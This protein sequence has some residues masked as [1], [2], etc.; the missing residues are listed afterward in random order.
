MFICTY[1][2]HTAFYACFQFQIYC[3]SFN[4]P[5]V[6]CYYLYLHIWTTSLNHVHMY[7][8][9]TPF[10]FI[11]IL[12]GCIWQPWILM[13][14][15]WS[16]D[17]G[18]LAVAD[19]STQR[20]LPWW[21]ECRKSSDIAVVLPPSF[22]PVWLSR[23]LL[24]L[25]SISQLLLYISLHVLYFYIFCWCNIPVILYHSLWWPCTCTIL[26]WNVYYHCASASDSSCTDA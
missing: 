26:C 14:R 15:S 7:L 4:F 16:L 3:R 22:S 1:T 6:I 8:L 23:S 9:C 11:Y 10:S 13:S 12:A 18:D 19:Q 24:L 2:L 25:V 5:Y 21:S 20:I 17:H